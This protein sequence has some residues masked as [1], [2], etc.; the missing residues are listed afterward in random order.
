V[1]MATIHVLTWIVEFII[2]FVERFRATLIWVAGLALIAAF[3]GGVAGATQ[4]LL[5]A[6]LPGIIAGVA[7]ALPALLARL[8]CELKLCRFLGV[9]VWALKWA[10]VIGGMLAV[11]L[12]SP[13]SGFVV[14]LYGG[15]VSALIWSLIR[16]GCPVPRLLGPP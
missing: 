6:V 15:T 8:V 13:G 1:V 5:P 11:L 4:G 7:V 9:F 10:I 12:L 14:V 2:C 3:V 16:K